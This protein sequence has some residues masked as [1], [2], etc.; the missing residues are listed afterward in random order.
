MQVRHPDCGIAAG[1]HAPS[2]SVRGEE[3]GLR[4]AV[5]AAW[6]A[7]LRCG[8]AR[9]HRGSCRWLAV[10]RG[11][12][13]RWGRRRRRRGR[14]CGQL[15]TGEAFELVPRHPQQPPY[16]HD[17]QALSSLGV[18][19]SL[20]ELVGRG[21]TDAQQPGCLCDRQE[22]RQPTGGR[23]VASKRRAIKRMDRVGQVGMGCHAS[24]RPCRTPIF[25]RESG[26]LPAPTGPASASDLRS[27]PAGAANPRTR[28]RRPRGPRPQ[29]WPAPLDRRRADLGPT[30]RHSDR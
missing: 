21:A 8:R 14:R 25:S 20:G 10:A 4:A 1:T 12:R 24:L 7:C 19:P 30:C 26:F 22:V 29:A 6:R 9:A 23:T 16:A 15:T 28:P 17:R 3:R 27:E 18:A 11:G 13:R 5:V 2:S